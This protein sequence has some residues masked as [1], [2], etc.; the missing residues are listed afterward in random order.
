MDLE[1][2]AEWRDYPRQNVHLGLPDDHMGRQL[3]A[4][5]SAGGHTVSPVSVDT[6]AVS[7]DVVVW[8]DPSIERTYLLHAIER[9]LPSTVVV[10]TG[11][12][13]AVPQLLNLAPTVARFVV[14]LH[15]QVLAVT[16]GRVPSLMRR[17]RFGLHSHVRI[18][19]WVQLDDLLAAV[20]HVIHDER[21]HGAWAVTG[22]VAGSAVEVAAAWHHTA[23]SPVPVDQPVPNGTLDVGALPDSINLSA[24]SELGYRPRFRRIEDALRFELGRIERLPTGRP[25]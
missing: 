6:A 20:L 21:A 4:F 23:S 15:G 24:L 3:M 8:R 11:D 7:P 16:C 18:D 2:H 1:R 25:V 5:L 17:A 10:L 13:S 12:K 22:Q 19:W 9:H 14:L